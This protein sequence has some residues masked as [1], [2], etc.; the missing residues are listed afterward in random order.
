MCS[1]VFF[2]RE[3]ILPEGRSEWEERRKCNEGEGMDKKEAIGAGGERDVK[4]SREIDF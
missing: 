4:W 1:H 3:R 2:C